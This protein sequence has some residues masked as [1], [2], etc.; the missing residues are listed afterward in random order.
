MEASLGH[1]ARWLDVAV[2]VARAEDDW[3]V[4]VDWR[5]EV[6]LVEKQQPRML[7]WCYVYPSV[8]S[9]HGGKDPI[10]R[11]TTFTLGGSRPVSNEM[12]RLL[13]S[14]MQTVELVWPIG[15]PNSGPTQPRQP[16]T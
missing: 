16:T 1:P 13:W 11:N 2:A 15:R 5:S 3:F 8:W 10:V 12:Y 7:L 4:R 6:V 9:P 14:C